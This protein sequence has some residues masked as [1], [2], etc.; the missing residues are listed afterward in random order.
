MQDD[1]GASREPAN[2]REWSQPTL[3][4]PSDTHF[5]VR[6]HTRRPEAPP[7]RPPYHPKDARGAGGVTVDELTAHQRA[8]EAFASVL[9][10]VQTD[11]LDAQ[12][13]CADWDA[14]AVIAH[15]LTGN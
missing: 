12:S 8:N 14:R 13:P 7:S 9:A 15:V 3:D 11:Q 6:P 4:E 5:L 1:P 10:K 2:E